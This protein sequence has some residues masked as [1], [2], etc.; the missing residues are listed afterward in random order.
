VARTEETTMT[1]QQLEH[2]AQELA[3]FDEATSTI[4]TAEK[5]QSVILVA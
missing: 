2:A 5:I 1:P 3:C 4:T